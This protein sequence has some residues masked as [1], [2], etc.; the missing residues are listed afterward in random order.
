MYKTYL[1]RVS[2]R[3]YSREGCRIIITIKFCNGQRYAMAMGICR[4]RDVTTRQRV[5]EITPRDDSTSKARQISRTRKK[6]GKRYRYCVGISTQVLYSLCADRD[7][8]NVKIYSEIV[9]NVGARYI[10]LSYDASELS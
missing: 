1:R 2:F 8:N 6:V 7:S 10:I 4:S 3:I 5:C 9:R